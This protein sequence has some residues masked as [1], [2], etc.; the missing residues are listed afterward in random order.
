MTVSSTLVIHSI[1]LQ[2]GSL[3]G[4]VAHRNRLTSCKQR[5]SKPIA[6]SECWSRNRLNRVSSVRAR[7]SFIECGDGPGY[8]EL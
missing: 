6:F 2:V 5:K 3:N 8:F 1:A 7:V 4:C